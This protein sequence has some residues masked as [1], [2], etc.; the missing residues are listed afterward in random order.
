MAL[1]E[2]DFPWCPET[3]PPEPISPEYAEV[4]SESE[5]FKRQIQLLSVT[6]LEKFELD[7]GE[8]PASGVTICRDNIRAHYNAQLNRYYAFYWTGI[9]SWL[10]ATS[11][12]VRYESY[13]EKP[14]PKANGTVW[15][16]KLVFRKEI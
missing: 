11:I 7:F 13:E 10:S 4:I 15:Q 2:A 9:P 5:V 3:I 14:I 1:P 16:V 12:H 6:P 8:I